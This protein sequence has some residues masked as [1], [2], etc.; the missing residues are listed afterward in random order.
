MRYEADANGDRIWSVTRFGAGHFRICVAIW[1]DDGWEPATVQDKCGC[2]R[3]LATPQERRIID[4][5][6]GQHVTTPDMVRRMY[7]PVPL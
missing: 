1:G 7:G 5:V 2:R 3:V 4:S 6:R